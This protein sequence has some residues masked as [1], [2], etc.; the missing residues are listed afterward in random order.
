[1]NFRYKVTLIEKCTDDKLPYYYTNEFTI[2]LV[3]QAANMIEAMDDTVNPCDDFYEFA[4]GGWI[5]S[6]VLPEDKSWNSILFEVGDRVEIKVK[7]WYSLFFM[8]F[9][10]QTNT[11]QET[12]TTI[13]Q[14]LCN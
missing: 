12:K 5:R 3:F 6:Y 14:T 13:N 2:Y 7:G 11:F 8:V 10:T 1:M 4:C 9:L